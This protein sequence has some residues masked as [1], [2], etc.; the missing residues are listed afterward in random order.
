MAGHSKWANIKRRK[1]VVDAAKSKVWTK[2]IRE[3]N[4]A[5]REG[6]GDPAG[7][8]RLSLAIDAAKAANMPKDNIERAIKKGIGDDKDAAQYVELLY[9]GY[10]PGGIAYM[11]E[12][13]S[14]NTNRT[15]GE[16]RHIFSK[17]GA[18]MG[19][20]GSVAYMFDRIGLITIKLQGIDEDEITLAAIE[21]GAE[22]IKT[23]DEV[24]EITTRREDLFAVRNA[25][26][27]AGY[28]IASAELQYIPGTMV[29]V[30]EETAL[31]NFKLMEKLEE[32][33]DVANVFN[34]ME[35][36][37][38]AMAAAEKL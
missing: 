29:K 3:I 25:L 35:L 5:A 9:E 33:D 18:S 23:E 2:V 11:V 26:E 19:T 16:I 14:D 28:T 36:D 34:N 10:G 1:A 8:P 7:N 38:T 32:N 27:Q 17:Y 21:A 24:F 15:A 6:G 22:D 4:V 20:S 12:A 13:T 37:E 31:G 30:D